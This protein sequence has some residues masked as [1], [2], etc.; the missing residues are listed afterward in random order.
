MLR[1]V[2]AYAAYQLWGSVIKPY[3]LSAGKPKVTCLQAKSLPRVQTPVHGA[4][5]KA[6]P[7]GNGT[8]VAFV[9]QIC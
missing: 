8:L 3:F 5:T 9:A 1:Q 4:C 7:D 2:P 6:G